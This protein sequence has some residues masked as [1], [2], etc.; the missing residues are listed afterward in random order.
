MKTTYTRNLMA[1]ALIGALA[2]VAADAQT[3]E[4]P[5]KFERGYPAADTAKRA[6][7]AADLRRA[8]EASRPR[9]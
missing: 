8:I 7:D 4:S 3:A 9:P 6:Y 5:Y 1:A 2:V